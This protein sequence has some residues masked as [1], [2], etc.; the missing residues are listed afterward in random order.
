MRARALNLRL[1]LAPELHRQLSDSAK[2]R[3]KSL[4]S[5]IIER[6]RYTFA[7]PSY[8]PTDLFELEELRARLVVLERAVFG[9][10]E[11]NNR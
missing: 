9:E 7:D 11:D 4:N 10:P 2:A 8:Q 6:L 3:G 1:R 5:E